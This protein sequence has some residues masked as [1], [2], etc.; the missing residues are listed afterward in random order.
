LAAGGRMENPRHQTLKGTL[1][2]SYE[3]LSEAERELFE[4]LSVF[5][6]GWTL[7]VA[8]EVGADDGI[9][10]EDVLDLL[11]RLI[12]KSLV[13]AEPEE[14][15]DGAM[16][17][18]M[19]EPVRQYAQEKLE[20][21]ERDVEATKRRYASFFLA[22]AEKAEPELEGPQQQELL[23]RL[24]VEHDNLRATLSWSLEQGEADL[25]LRLGGALAWFWWLRGHS[26]EGRWWLEAALTNLEAASVPA[27]AKGLTRAGR[28]VWEQGDSKRAAALSEAG[29]ILS[30]KLGDTA[31]TA[32]GLVN[33]GTI[34]LFQT[35]FERASA[36]LKEAVALQRTVIALQTLG[37]VVVCQRDYE[38]AMALH[39][40]TLALSQKMED[41]SGTTLSLF[42]GALAALGLG[43][44]QRVRELCAQGLGLCQDLGIKRG[45]SNN[46]RVLAGL[47]SSQGRP[48][49]S[50][51]L[52]GAAEVLYEAI[53]TPLSPVERL[54]FGPYIDA[55]H[56]QL[57][58]ATWEVAWAEG[59]SM[60]LEE[61]VEYAFSEEE[62]KKPPPKE[63]TDGR[64]PATLTRREREVASLV[65]R[66]LTNR[67]IA[68]ELSISE[69]TVDAHLRKILKK[70]G[71]G[72]R[73]Q[74]AAWVAEQGPL[75]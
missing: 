40:E 57:N 71:F 42:L 10:E 62:E 35:N 3:L 31:G 37:L 49:R 27:Q 16:R 46:L 7:E 52:W 19:L 32:E 54:H 33:L 34:A 69:R 53:G 73:A 65:G 39:E 20:K 61:A 60:T 75:S 63:S 28:I 50:A 67:Q 45:I 64:Q 11:S 30:R 8:E 72:S 55:A 5:A 14:K 68:E 4:R 22:L 12:D 29:L 58:E 6:G 15:W 48:V 18:R 66:G 23:E 2:W 59:R 1:D 21:S 17:Y 56:A 41:K 25:G 44:H 70:L 38:R 36:L 26:S 9:E 51:R 47:A 24:E 13:V 43:Y 74:I